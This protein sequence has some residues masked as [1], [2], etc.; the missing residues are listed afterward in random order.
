MKAFKSKSKKKQDEKSKSAKSEKKKQST[1]QSPPSKTDVIVRFGKPVCQINFKRIK[2]LTSVAVIL[3]IIL[4]LVSF[5]FIITAIKIR[6]HLGAF[7][8]MISKGDGEILPTLLA[9][10]AFCFICLNIASTIF[11]Y[12]IFSVKK[13]PGSN[14]A[15]FILILAGF[16][17]MVITVTVKIITLVHMYKSHQSLHSGIIDTMKKYAVNSYYKIEMDRLQI[18]FKCCGS[19]KYDDWYNV[20]WFEKD[21]SSNTSIALSGQTPYSCCAMRTSLPCIHY[22]IEET[23]KSYNYA[24]EFN[25]TIN[26][27]GCYNRILEKKREVGLEI[28]RDLFILF[29][30]ELLVLMP[31]RFLQ[32][33][34]SVD[35][36]FEGNSKKYTV[37]LLGIYKGKN[38]SNDAPEPPP[39]PAELMQ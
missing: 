5:D 38:K 13:S 32:T 35:S 16:L 22:D 30:L 21:V 4:I 24:P 34:H 6:S 26:T 28:V 36:K 1:N 31:M 2:L 11:I 39:L 17:L 15:L 20:S 18:E 29:F 9:V 25:L 27:V 23:G 8:N 37:W 14:R 10:P 12:K 7:I 3:I 33:G 19:K